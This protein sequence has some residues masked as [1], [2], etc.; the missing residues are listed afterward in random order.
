MQSGTGRIGSLVKENDVAKISKSSEGYKG[1]SAVNGP[2][3]KKR[4]T[5][6]AAPIVKETS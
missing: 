6:A 2:F 1:D 4:K 3:E 5:F